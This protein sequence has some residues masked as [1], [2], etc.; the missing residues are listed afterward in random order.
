[1]GGKVITV[2]STKGGVGKSTLARFIAITANEIGKKVCIIDTCQNS[3]IATGF[4]RDRDSFSKNA[5]DWLIGEAKPSEVINQ[6]EDTS[7]YYIPSDERI[8]DF[9]EWVDRKIPKPRQL[10]VLKTKIEPLKKI[11]DYIVIDTHPSENSDIVNYSIAASEFCVIPLEIDLDAKLAASRCV[12]IIRDYQNAGYQIDYGIVWNKVEITK[13]KAKAQLDKIKEELISKGIPPEKFIGDIRYS[14]TVSTSKN[15][16][17]ML[18]SV[19]NKYTQNVM[20]DIRNVS[21]KIFAQIGEVFS[22]G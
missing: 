7:I 3:S 8:D 17:I 6:Y 21:Q 1:M 15:D 10:E 20:N 16:G 18:N 13:G 4:L 14:T 12:E 9:E 22:Y 11:F 2:L 19:N 5:Y